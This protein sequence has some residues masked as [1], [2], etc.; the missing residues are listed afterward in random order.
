[1]TEWTTIRV[2][3]AARDEADERKPDDVTWSE[4]IT[5]E[6]EADLDPDIDEDA[7]ADAVTEDLLAQLP[8]AIADELR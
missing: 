6:R 3:K 2:R 5:G 8:P 7:I 1:M 4:W